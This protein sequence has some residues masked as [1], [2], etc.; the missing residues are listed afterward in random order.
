MGE[1]IHPVIYQMASCCADCGKVLYY[2]TRYDAVFCKVCDKWKETN[3]GN[4]NCEYCAGRPAQPS[5][6][7]KL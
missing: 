1:K 4:P 7:G 6:I 3:C 2:H 5:K